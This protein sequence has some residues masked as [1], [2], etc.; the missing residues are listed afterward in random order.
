VNR[1]YLTSIAY[2]TATACYLAAV[3]PWRWWLIA[4]TIAPLT[5]IVTHTPLMLDAR[6]A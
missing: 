1:Y 3:L 4:L 6:I 2:T 5:S